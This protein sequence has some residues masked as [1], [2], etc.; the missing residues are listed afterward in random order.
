MTY[1]SLP[2]DEIAAL[3][4]EGMTLCAIAA[5]FHV[6]VPTIKAR[7]R[8]AQGL[9]PRNKPPSPV[10]NIPDEPERWWRKAMDG[11]RFQ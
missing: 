4:A 3:R 2:T 10:K 5:R 8:K 6:T 11:K 7:L 9:A 1:L